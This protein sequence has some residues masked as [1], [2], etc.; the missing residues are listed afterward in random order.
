MSSVHWFQFKH[1]SVRTKLLAGFAAAALIALIVGGIGVQR[2]QVARDANIFLYEKVTLP[3]GRLA[4]LKSTFQNVQASLRAYM[5]TVDEAEN[6]LLDERLT[7]DAKSISEQCQAIEK[8]LTAPE[9]KSLFNDFTERR[10]A[11]LPV[12]GEIMKLA[13]VNK[14]AE[15]Y[16]LFKAQGEKLADSVEASID[17]MT[18]ELSSQAKT[19][20]E[21]S[22][23]QATTGMWMM[24]FAVLVGAILSA[25]LGLVI[26]RG[27]VKPLEMVMAALAK[28]ASGELNQKLEVNSRDEVGQIAV[29]L[30]RTTDG[31]REA[32]QSDKVDWAIV[33]SQRNEMQRT[34]QIVENAAFNLIMADKDLKIRYLNRAA[35]KTLKTLQQYLPIPVE[36]MVG[37]SIDVFHKQP[38]HQRRLVSDPNNLPFQATIQVGPE[39]LDLRVSA[40]FDEQGKY[41]GPL[42][43]WE[44][45]TQKVQLE[46]KNADYAGQVAAIGK[47]QAVIEFNMDGTIREANDNF[48]KAVGYSLDEIKGRHHSLFVDEG[49]R[50]SPE[51]KEFWASLNRG[52]YQA[53]EYKRLGKGGKE[54]HIQASYNPILDVNGKPFKVVKYA[55]DITAEVN[56]REDL[57]NKVNCML[58][59][60][61]AA[62]T[63]DLTREITV[64]GSD[65]IGQMGEGL[66]RF[67]RD[68]RSSIASIASNAMSLGGSAEEL[69]AVSSQMSSNAEETSAQANVV[70]AASEQVS[71]NVQ[72]VTT[73]VEEMGVSIREIAGSA[74]KSA[75]VAQQAVE[76]AGATNATIAKLGDSS[77]EIG[78]VINVITSIAEQTNLLALNA[79]I[80]AAR[81]GEAGKGFAVV[82]NEVK[83]LAKETAK[84]TEDIRQKIEAIQ[85][86]TRGAVDAIKQISQIIGEVNDLSNTIASAVEEQT[87]TAKEIGRN[88]GEAAKGTGEIAQNITSVAQAAQNTTQ[89]ATNTQQAAEELA[90]MAAELQQLVSKFK[91][92][93]EGK[94]APTLRTA[95]STKSTPSKRSDQSLKLGV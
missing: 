38:E 66:A 16:A 11:W 49:Y 45:C 56:A 77:A 46:A 44:V 69:S 32:L 62:A 80:E 28:V 25:T 9:M 30:N 5:L 70:S 84:A 40:T 2:L 23:S 74:T 43:A 41:S 67:F 91:F 15:A 75:K 33:G 95:S 64:S 42:L 73:G 88:V 21:Q 29:A 14:N 20:A 86:D 78:K 94:E 8:D 53:A 18:A 51:Y 6:K 22:V 39:Y 31:M 12:R 24:G 26:A 87:A 54:I 17:K 27:I 60:V 34:K 81:A 58:E 1:W 65:S 93:T 89:G 7:S 59:V 47:S 4:K 90:R 55:T 76:V 68:L 10:Q 82:A 83:E 63:G 72:T 48:L 61:A 35:I 57:K 92:E 71:S 52:E 50:H 3:S 85:L 13:A 79:T 19:A 37:Q 36:Q